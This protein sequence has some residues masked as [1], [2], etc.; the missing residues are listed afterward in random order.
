MIP[1]WT[2]EAKDLKRQ[3]GGLERDVAVALQA[4]RKDVPALVSELDVL[5]QSLEAD[6]VK[7]RTS[8]LQQVD[9]LK[10]T[11]RDVLWLPTAF[12]YNTLS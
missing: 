1:T 6:R 4:L 8:L 7:E 3:R 10:V 11:C 9:R 5:R 2:S 12:G